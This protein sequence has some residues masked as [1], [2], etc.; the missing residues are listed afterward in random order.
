MNKIKNIVMLQ[1]VVIIYSISSVMSKLASGTEGNVAKF[2]LFFGLE[3]LFLGI[4]A[5]LWQQM[6]KRFDLTVAYA[7]RAMVILWST[8]WA[9]IFFHNQI[10][11]QNICG[12][13]LVMLGTFLVNV[14]DTENKEEG[15]DD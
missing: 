7:N 15:R 6:I 9:V 2:I 12:I 13:L 4:Y 11:L 14:G 1:G 8:I 3:F 5:I 10:T